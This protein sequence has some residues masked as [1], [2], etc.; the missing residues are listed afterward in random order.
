LSKTQ[1]SLFVFFA[2]KAKRIGTAGNKESA[3]LVQE[4][5]PAKARGEAFIERR[6]KFLAS[7]NIHRVICRKPKFPLLFPLHRKQREL[8]PQATKEAHDWLKRMVP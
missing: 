3:R 1:I 7:K 8:A 6:S 5:G 4:D 2:Q